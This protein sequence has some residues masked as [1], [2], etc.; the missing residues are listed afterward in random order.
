MKI[1]I[2][3]P[4]NIFRHGGVQES[5]F[6]HQQVL[7]EHGHEVRIVSPKPLSYSEKPPKDIILVGVSTDINYPFRTKA[8]ISLSVGQ[9]EMKAMLAEEK[10][11]ILHFHEPWVPLFSRQLLNLCTCPKVGTFHAKWPEKLIYRTFGKAIRPYARSIVDD[12]DYVAAASEP[13]SRYVS[14]LLGRPV[15][16]I[17]NGIDLKRFDPN[18]AEPIKRYQSNGKTIL[19]INRLEK[20]KG[21]DLLLKAYREL[22]KKHRDLKL[23]MASDGDMRAKLEAYVEKYKLPGVEFI[24]FVDDETKVKLYASADVYC[25][26][27][28]YGEGF[29]IVLLEAM[30]MRLPYV[31][32]DNVG[33]R[34]A[35]GPRADDYLVDPT[36]AKAL[37]DKLEEMLF[38]GDK[39]ARYK[40]WSRRYATKYDYENIVK[41]YEAVYKKLVK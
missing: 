31:G 3:C 32:G 25:A 23:V 12:L 9:S 41:E 21:P 35:S 36:D 18:K 11:D 40:R 39:R 19:Y 28:P 20:R 1:G 33:Y 14:E 22:S 2:V 4:Y 30:A 5:I 37:A 34:Y 38:D 27:S 10:F 16:I 29:G 13:G 26:P 6:A 8:D 7:T 17:F 24:G 15:H